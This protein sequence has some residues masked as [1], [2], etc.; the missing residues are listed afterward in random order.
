MRHT[1]DG[2]GLTALPRSTAVL[3]NLSMTLSLV[4]VTGVAAATLLRIFTNRELLV[5]L[6]LSVV[7]PMACTLAARLTRIPWIV[8]LASAVV[9]EAA[10]LAWWIHRATGLPI[11]ASTPR[12]AAAIMRLAWSTID[13]LKPPIAP[14][15][16]FALMAM[17]G[18]WVVASVAD[19]VAFRLR[20]PLEALIPSV[21]ML[22][23]SSALSRHLTGQPRVR[24]AAVVVGVGML[25]VFVAASHVST[26]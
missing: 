24:S 2:S 15:L 5:P 21:A 11:T 3:D 25:H 18:T 8:G 7:G 23:V 16:G 9:A 12:D 19:T 14:Q 10:V 26:L 1:S 13:D 17:L 4:L 20:S 6:L 22:A